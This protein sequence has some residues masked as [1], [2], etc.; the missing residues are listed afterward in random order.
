MLTGVFVHFLHAKGIYA[1]W[2]AFGGIF[3]WRGF[4]Y[5]LIYSTGFPRTS[6]VN[7]QVSANS[8]FFVSCA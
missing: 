2:H 1:L 4:L 7:K 3:I 8:R 6:V 5:L